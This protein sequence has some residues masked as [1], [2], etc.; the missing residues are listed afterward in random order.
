[1]NKTTQWDYVVKEVTGAFHNGC[2]GK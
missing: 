2:P 1:M